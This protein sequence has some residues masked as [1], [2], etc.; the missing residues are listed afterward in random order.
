M[1]EP[2]RDYVEALPENAN[3]PVELR[4]SSAGECARKLE[5]DFRDLPGPITMEGYLRMEIGKLIHTRLTE[6]FAA[7]YKEKFHSVDKDVEL[8]VGLATR[9]L[10]IMGHPDGVLDLDVGGTVLEFKSCSD[11]TFTKIKNENKP[12]DAHIEQASCYA[13][14][15]KLQWASVI[16]L[17]RETME[18]KVFIFEVHPAVVTMVLEKFARVAMNWETK[19]VGPRP[20]ADM[21]EAPC[22]YCFHKSKCYEGFKQEVENKLEME[23]TDQTHA[24]LAGAIRKWWSTRSDRLA[25]EKVE[26]VLKKEVGD[27]LV[28]HKVN[29]VVLQGESK[30]KV[31]VTVGKNNN[32]LPAIKEIK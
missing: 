32:L 9:D 19:Q 8:V 15:L 22:W 1:I 25:A 6:L 14:A 23:I 26:D 12:L 5:Y 3:H 31:T 10:V 28:S 27:M 21:T 13:T 29:E 20:Y 24:I 2:V 11:A 16:Y 30:Y 17:N 7:T 4:M 18:F